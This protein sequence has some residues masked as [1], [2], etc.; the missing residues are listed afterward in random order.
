MSR[1]LHID[2]VKIARFL[3]G[4]L[5]FNALG[6]AEKHEAIYELHRRGVT[7][8]TAH[9]LYRITADAYQRRLV[10]LEAPRPGRPRPTP[11]PG[12]PQCVGQHELFELKNGVPQQA[13]LN[14][15]RS[16]TV[17]QWCL[18][19]VRPRTSHYSGVAAGIGWVNGKPFGEPKRGSR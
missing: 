4:D 16:C 1:R 2:R 19:T 3:Q 5:P 14:L 7:P 8:D 15:C 9:S 13:A 12:E 17:Q 18:E 6:K 11:P 10:S